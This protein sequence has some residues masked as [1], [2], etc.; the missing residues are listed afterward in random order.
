[1]RI[2][3]ERILELLSGGEKL[4][5]ARLKALKITKEIQG[6]GNFVSSPS[7]SSSSKM[8]NASTFGSNST[9]SSPSCWE[10][11][12][13]TKHDTQH[14]SAKN[15]ELDSISIGEMESEKFSTPTGDCENVE[16]SHGWEWDRHPV[17]E[18]CSLLDSEDDNGEG[19]EEGGKT[20]GFIKEIC[21]KFG[22]KSPLKRINGEKVPF[23]SL[24]DVGKLRR[25]KVDRQF[26]KEY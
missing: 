2:R 18:S 1:M 14:A 23:R 25:K 6:F 20:Y 10:V 24:S 22:G 9:S 8:S 4:K 12:A 13:K 26:S 15:G 11:G 19:K 5:Q 3:S 21:S 16:G 17:D 7:S